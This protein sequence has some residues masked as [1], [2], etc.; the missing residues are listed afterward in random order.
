MVTYRRRRNSAA[1][2]NSLKVEEQISIEGIHIT[3]RRS[4]QEPGPVGGPMLATAQFRRVA[5]RPDGAAAGNL[6]CI[7]W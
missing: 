6:T 1:A 3:A 5:T 7:A 2:K 4:I